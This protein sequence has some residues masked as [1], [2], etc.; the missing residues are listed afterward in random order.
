MAAVF[1]HGFMGDA[2]ST[3]RDFQTIIDDKHVETWRYTDLYFYEYQGAR[4]LAVVSA[5]HFQ[6]FVDSIFP[7]P[8]RGLFTPPTHGFQVFP[9]DR[10]MA[11]REQI[12]PYK[13]LLLIGHS[14]GAL[15]IRQAVVSA[16][17]KHLNGGNAIE[18]APLWLRMSML[19]FFAPAHRGFQPKTWA[20]LVHKLA[21]ESQLTAIA[22]ISPVF[23][24]LLPQSALIVDLQAR[25]KELLTAY[26]TI[27]SLRARNLFGEDER[28]V[29]P[30][31]YDGDLETKY[32]N[33]VGHTGVCKPNYAFLKPL[34]FLS[35]AWQP[36]TAKA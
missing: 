14:L 17:R 10:S 18:S 21:K 28:I 25:T 12:G 24:D 9:R 1:V 26:P 36:R 29:E 31:D 27:S 34:E 13:Q 33:G 23:A 19:C 8:A 4:N 11:V 6:E 5:Q 32:I 22:N 2:G 30:L 20:D 15:V 16:L 35:D 3:W 7:N